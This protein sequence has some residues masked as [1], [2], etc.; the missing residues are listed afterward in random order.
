MVSMVV[1]LGWRLDLLSEFFSKYNISVIFWFS[2]S[3]PIVSPPGLGG[4]WQS[5]NSKE[6][7]WSGLVCAQVNGARGEQINSGV[8][9]RIFIWSEHGWLVEQSRNTESFRDAL[10]IFTPDFHPAVPDNPTQL[11]KPLENAATGCISGFKMVI[12]PSVKTKQIN[13]Q[14]NRI[15]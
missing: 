1:V 4:S 9:R 7:G 3:Q 10:V 8:V 15:R 13:F 12:K 2:H 11:S 5:L 6:L 14:M